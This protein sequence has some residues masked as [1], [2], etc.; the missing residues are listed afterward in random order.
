MLQESG[1]AREGWGRQCLNEASG[2]TGNGPAVK[3]GAWVQM[4]ALGRQSRHSR[5][6]DQ[7]MCAQKSTRERSPHF[8]ARANWKRERLRQE[9][10]RNIRV[11]AS[12][13][14]DFRSGT[15]GRCLG[16]KDVCSLT[17]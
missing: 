1:V 9:A 3:G 4:S 16:S 10:F 8:H 2:K 17:L 15:S 12:E 13:G 14:P 7:G 5:G 11:T 6:S